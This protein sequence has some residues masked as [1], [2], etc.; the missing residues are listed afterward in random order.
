MS[1]LGRQAA[2][3]VYSTTLGHC[4]KLKNL[5]L[6][7]QTAAY[8]APTLIAVHAPRS[9]ALNSPVYEI[10]RSPWISGAVSLS[11]SVWT[12]QQLQAWLTQ[13]INHRWLF[14]SIESWVGANR[15]T[16]LL[17]NCSVPDFVLTWFVAH[18][19]FS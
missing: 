17:V 8:D 16:L 6:D 11:V 10:V 5:T 4:L 13:A 9:P 18:P 15:K 7:L 14:R 19:S 1:L 12:R 3:V 2:L